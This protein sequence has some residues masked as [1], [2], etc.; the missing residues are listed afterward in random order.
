MPWHMVTDH[1]RT[2]RLKQLEISQ[3]E[4]L[5]FAIHVVRQRGHRLGPASHWLIEDLRKRLADWQPCQG[6]EKAEAMARKI[7]A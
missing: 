2:G 1:I 4:G 6:S 5:T 7:S 3:S